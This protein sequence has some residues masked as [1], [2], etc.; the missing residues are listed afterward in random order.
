ML[1]IKLILKTDIKQNEE[2][3]K[4]YESL[5]SY[6]DVGTQWEWLSCFTEEFRLDAVEVALV[7]HPDWNISD[8]QKMM[9]SNLQGKG[10]FCRLHNSKNSDLNLFKNFTFPVI[11]LTKSDLRHKAREYGFYDLLELTWFCHKPSDEGLP[12][13][14]CHPCQR[15]KESGFEYNFKFDSNLLS[16]R[17]K[18]IAKGTAKKICR[19]FISN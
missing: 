19:T 17:F 14:L 16:N 10:H 6:L 7:K 13:G 8:L 3:T 15:A 4:W 1:P 18:R 9:L 2:I 12:C 11:H 5:K